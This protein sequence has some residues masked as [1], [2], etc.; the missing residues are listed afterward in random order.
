MCSRRYGRVLGFKVGKNTKKRQ[1]N[2]FNFSAE[3]ANKSWKLQTIL[4]K[5]RY[6]QKK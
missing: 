1:K 6:K 3:E 5:K 2:M 4:P